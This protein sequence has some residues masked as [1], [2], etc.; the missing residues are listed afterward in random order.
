MSL[1]GTVIRPRFLWVGGRFE[2]ARL[3]LIYQI[4]PDV[5]PV[6]G[7]K[8]VEWPTLALLPGFINTHSHAFHRHLRGRSEIGNEGGDTF[9]R[10][11]DNMYNLVDDVDWDGMKKL[12]LATFREMIQAGIT[13][14][15]EF[16]YVHH[17]SGRFDLDSAVLAA[18]KEAGIR[19]CLLTT[20]YEQAG[21]D[22]PEPHVIQKKR[23]ISTYD[24][25]IKHADGL[26]KLEDETTTIGVA[27]HSARA[28]PF[29]HIG[30]LWQWAEQQQL[31]FHIHLEEQPKELADC[32]KFMN[33]A[34][35]PVDVILRRIKPGPL[36]TGVHNT[37]TTA[38]NME[39]LAELG[40]NVSVCPCT[41]GYLGDGIP[42]ISSKTH[43]SFGTDCNNRICFIEELRWAAF[44]QHAKHNSRNIAGL[45]AERLL[46]H[47]TVGGARSLNL[48]KVCGS[49]D[50][51]KAF[52]CVAFDAASPVIAGLNKDELA[53]G[54]VFGCGNREIAKVAVQGLI[55]HEKP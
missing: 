4:G 52:D 8:L 39:K 22:A 7:Q 36:F 43:L 37:Y 19:I 46:K 35:T 49:F 41:E 55:R 25:F 30:E 17:G 54:I 3:R 26:R 34:Q 27:A 2:E 23:F 12:C 48:S 38:E 15:G 10:W 32:Q 29:A 24:D 33:S 1:R 20:L 6:D 16:H 44:T 50:V 31:P 40:A 45:S 9:W 42:A 13:T 14:V 53:D 47:A 18:A 28:V 51:G 21:F 11:R 5:E